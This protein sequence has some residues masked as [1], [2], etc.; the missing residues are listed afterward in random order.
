MKVVDTIQK[1]NNNQEIAEKEN[2]QG[3]E[4]SF[5]AQ[6]KINFDLKAKQK[7]LFDLTLKTVESMANKMQENVLFDEMLGILNVKKDDVV[8]KGNYIIKNNLKNNEENF[9]YKKIEK[10][11]VDN[12]EKGLSTLEAELDSVVAPSVAS[13]K[14]I[15]Q[16]FSKATVDRVHQNIPKELEKNNEI[17]EAIKFIDENYENVADSFKL[18]ESEIIEDIN[19]QKAHDAMFKQIPSEELAVFDAP[20]FVKFP[21]QEGDSLSNNNLVYGLENSDIIKDTAFVDDV[22]A[23]QDLKHHDLQITKENKEYIKTLFKSFGEMNLNKKSELLE[24]DKRFAFR[25]VIKARD[26][27]Y[28]AYQ[29]FP[30]Q[31]YVEDGQ[32][33]HLTDEEYKQKLTEHY[34]KLPKQV[35]TYKKEIENIEKLYKIMDEHEAKVST[36][37]VTNQFY[38]TN[39]KETGI[40]IVPNQLKQ[41]YEKMAKLNSIFSIYEFVVDHKLEDNLDDFLEHPLQYLSAKAQETMPSFDSFF[42]D[43]NTFFNQIKDDQYMSYVM[44]E[45]LGAN[46]TQKQI[47]AWR[48]N[49]YFENNLKKVAGH[50]ELL[51]FTKQRDILSRN[52]DD[53]VDALSNLETDEKVKDQNQFIAEKAKQTYLN[54]PYKVP[55]FKASQYLSDPGIFQRLAIVN[56]ADVPNYFEKMCT[57]NYNYVTL[58]QENDKPFDTIEYLNNMQYETRFDLT[59][60]KLDTLLNLAN[61]SLPNDKKEDA[62]AQV[63]EGINKYCFFREFDSAIYDDNGNKT[64]DQDYQSL[65]NFITNPVEYMT[66]KG[67]VLTE[68]QKA[69]MREIASQ[70]NVYVSKTEQKNYE[71]TLKQDLKN[72]EKEF[73]DKI[74]T[75]DKQV[76]SL[77]DQKGAL[78]LLAGSSLLFE[79]TEKEMESIKPDLSIK[80]QQILLAKAQIASLSYEHAQSLKQDLI[81]GKIT[82]SYFE[83]RVEQLMTLSPVKEKD[84]PQLFEIDKFPKNA[85]KWFEQ[86]EYKNEKLTNE[87]KQMLFASNK[88]RAEIEKQ[89]LLK[90]GAYYELSGNANKFKVD[91]P[92]TITKLADESNFLKLFDNKQNDQQIKNEQPNKNQN[93]VNNLENANRKKISINLNE[94]KEI[95]KSNMVSEN[96]EIKKDLKK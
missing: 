13:I 4:K 77:E 51:N 85:Q 66:G 76:K 73:N 5:Q 88:A 70:R 16:G 40:Q 60:L 31:D 35:E 72:K 67:I 47:D 6:A 9:D 2:N 41:D 56:E 96:K 62:F 90:N 74:T 50:M 45:D 1:L 81:A 19:E 63:Y 38:I 64:I 7:Y 95:K 21:K 48:E 30:K 49:K 91:I 17:L 53:V 83:K 65:Q 34:K 87:E 28:Y 71:N 10:F 14:E 75:L 69:F 26:A 36:G 61:E 58:Q 29:D 82:K 84:L 20:G 32:R 12:A 68:G 37:S 39:S 44:S 43:K 52:V 94:N 22:F 79:P 27:L 93:V 11:F 92:S 8:G 24:D 15:N 89:H 3:A 55:T 23:L 46:P 59:K 25:N 57:T 42:V 86:S 78:K 33:I 54:A 18:M 80:D